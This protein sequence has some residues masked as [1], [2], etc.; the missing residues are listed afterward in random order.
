MGFGCDADWKM[1]AVEVKQRKRCE[2]KVKELIKLLESLEES[3]ED[4]EIRLV[5]RKVNAEMVK[6]GDYVYGDLMDVQPL[7]STVYMGADFD[8]SF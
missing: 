6:D 4:V 2:M 8:S 1:A 3:R 5:I 7:G